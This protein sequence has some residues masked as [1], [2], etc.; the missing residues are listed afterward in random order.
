M[1]KKHLQK[2]TVRAYSAVLVKFNVRH[3][4]GEESLPI[5]KI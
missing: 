3:I 4:L 2:Y 1:H 5:Y